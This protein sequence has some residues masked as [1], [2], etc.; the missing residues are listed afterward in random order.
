VKENSKGLF[1]SLMTPRTLILI[2]NHFPYTPG[3]SFLAPEYNAL[4]TVF[5]RVLILCRHDK[6]TSPP[7]GYAIKVVRPT[8][9]FYEYVAAVGIAIK[10]LPAILAALSVELNTMQRVRRLKFVNVK[11]CLHDLGKA[12]ITANQISLL[13]QENK[14]NGKLVLYS[15]WLT[16]SALS[17]LFVKNSRCEIIRVSRAHGGDIYEERNSNQ[18]LSFRNTLVKHLNAVFVASHN[19]ADYL[20]KKVHPSHHFKIVT[21]RLGS[22]NESGYTDW[23]TSSTTIRIVSCSFLVPVKRVHL[24]I[25]SLK[26]VKD[27]TLE[28]I[29]IGGGPFESYLR[30]EAESLCVNNTNISYKFLG[31]LTPADVFQ[32]YQNTPVNLFINTSESEG[33]PVSMMEAQSFGIPIVALNVGGVSEIVNDTNGRLLSADSKREDIADA[34]RSILELPTNDYVK[35]RR[36]A[37]SNWETHYN[38]QRNFST[39]ANQILA[40][41]HDF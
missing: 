30:Q 14:I 41:F 40:L 9:T 12:L 15:Y 7:S 37:R 1:K 4:K 2:T 34:I 18:F 27:Y 17:T 36:S 29:H 13:I 3:E 38:A 28:W 10:N 25:E 24:I 39:F 6:L 26:L 19:G 32:F 11:T 21:A 20:R 8:S 31:T 23:S 5:D 16:S 35:L 22:I 33:I